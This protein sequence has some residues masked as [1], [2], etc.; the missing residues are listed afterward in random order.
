MR[1]QTIQIFLPDGSPTSI[2]EAEIT[3]R[4]VK[5]ILFPRNKMQEVSQR[6]MVHFTGVYFLFGTSEDGTK[7]MVY[8]GEGEDCF[9]RIQ[10][11]NR[12]KDFW[13]H[14]VIVASKTNDYNKAD[15]KFLEHYCIDKSKEIDRY[16]LD[17]D[18]GSNRLYISESREHDLLDNFETAKILLATLGY[19]I[20]EEK[21]KAKSNKELFYCQGKDA[22][23]V[24]E[25]TDDGF[26]VYKEGKVNLEPTKGMNKWIGILRN[27]LIEEEILKRDNNVY[28]FQQDFI[29]NSPSAAAATILGRSANG[30]TSWK[31]KNGL[32]L[33]EIKRK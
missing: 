4:L 19:P 17:N 1:P 6:E 33:D 32:T 9:K 3:S 23:A 10:S 11:H 14:C 28:V 18:T 7:P 29:F 31:D 2:R 24:G 30:W 22:Y 21:R 27:R 25:L 13:T 15:S 26:L 20:F 12:N 8:I 5:A 16:K